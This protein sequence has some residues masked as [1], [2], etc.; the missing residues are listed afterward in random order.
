M[1][2]SL[3]DLDVV[4]EADL[5]GGADNWDSYSRA[6]NALIM[7]EDICTRLGDRK[8]TKEDCTNCLLDILA[9]QGKALEEAAKLILDTLAQLS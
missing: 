8:P 2:N 3:Q 4:T 6:G 7:C 5:L 1:Y 9:M